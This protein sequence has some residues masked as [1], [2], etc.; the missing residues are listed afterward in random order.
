MKSIGCFQH[1]LEGQIGNARR[2]RRKDYNSFPLIMKQTGAA[3]AVSVS[4]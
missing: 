4:K 2:K 3:V 1:P